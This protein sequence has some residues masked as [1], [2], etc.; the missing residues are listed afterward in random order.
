MKYSVAEGLWV[1]DFLLCRLLKQQKST[2][3]KMARTPTPTPTPMPIFAPIERPPL[4]VPD[5][6]P[7][8]W[9]EGEGPLAPPDGFPPPP[10]GDDTFWQMALPLACVMFMVLQSS[11]PQDLIV[12]CPAATLAIGAYNLRIH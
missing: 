9:L 11:L 2:A 7:P 3:A 6:E 5:E 1:T 8:A 12:T 4:L 10:V